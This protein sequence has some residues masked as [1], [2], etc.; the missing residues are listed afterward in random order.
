[1]ATETS[2]SK[3]TSWMNT[4]PLTPALKHLSGELIA[5]MPWLDKVS[6]PVQSWLA[7][8]YGEPKAPSYRLKD[9]LNGV[10]FGHPLHPVLVTIP[11]G[12]WTT[13]LL[14]DTVWLA[15]QDEGVARSADLTMWLGLV[16]ALGSAVTGATQWIDTDGSE[17]RTGMLHALLNTTVTGINL[18]SAIMRLTGQR[19]TAITLAAIGYG[20]ASYSAYIGGELSYS[21]AIGVNHVAW[22]GGSDDYV[23][24]LDEKELQQGKLT[25]VDA[26]GIPAVLV[27]D[28][29]AIYA[30]AATCSHLG[31]PLDEGSYE[32]GVVY[33][34]WHRSGFRMCDGSVANSPATC[35]QPTFAVRTRNGKIELRR[36]EHA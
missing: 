26:A 10:W 8:L 15:D 29:N 18:T 20:I 2:V 22:E 12:A 9:F 34:P 28:G 16:G 19:R 21:N 7:S 33:C 36:L 4:P 6:S 14:L 30:I 24:V 31:G 5:R 35:G 17:Q 13:T 1:M 11:I 23:A 3:K 27:K 25:R 32:D